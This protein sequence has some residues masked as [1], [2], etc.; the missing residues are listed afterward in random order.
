M[1]TKED[2]ISICERRHWSSIL[3]TSTVSL[4]RSGGSSQNTVGAGPRAPSKGGIIVGKKLGAWTKSEGAEAPGPGLE[5]PLLRPHWRRTFWTSL[6]PI[7]FS[8]ESRH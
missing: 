1:I 5:P 4:R 8:K 3:A 6:R 7:N 2:K